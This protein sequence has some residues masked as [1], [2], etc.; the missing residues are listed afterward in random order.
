[1]MLHLT[2]YCSSQC[3]EVYCTQLSFN[4]YLLKV[5]FKSYFE[6]VTPKLGKVDLI[7]DFE[8]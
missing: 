1:M 8:K 7:L 2:L 3:S 5:A 4:S 6:K